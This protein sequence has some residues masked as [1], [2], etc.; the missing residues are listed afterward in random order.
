M[1]TY[2]RAPEHHREFLKKFV[3]DCYRE[4]FKNKSGPWDKIFVVNSNIL[5]PLKMN[6]RF[7]MKYSG[8]LMSFFSVLS[9]RK[10]DDNWGAYWVSGYGMKI[11]GNYEMFEKDILFL[12]MENS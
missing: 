3:N 9:N 12:K 4:Q 5:G 7:D 2:I 1:T 11:Y 6:V 10:D 8:V